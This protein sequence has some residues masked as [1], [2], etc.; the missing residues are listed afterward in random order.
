MRRSLPL[1]AGLSAAIL[2]IVLTQVGGN[3]SPS[4]NLTGTVQPASTLGTQTPCVAINNGSVEI[5]GADDV[6][7]VIRCGSS[8]LYKPSKPHVEIRRATVDTSRVTIRSDAT[9]AGG[10]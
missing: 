10:R 9:P 3:V 6:R 2:V 8:Y 5:S 1:V 7:V 4:D